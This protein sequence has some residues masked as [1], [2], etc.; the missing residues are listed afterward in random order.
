M[1]KAMLTALLCGSIV[2][3]I[4]GCDNSKQ[5]TKEELRNVNNVIIEYFSTNGVESY[6]N[7]IF[8]YVD[9][10]NG[11]VV[12]GLLN[13]DE[14]EQKNFKKEII[15]SDVIKFVKGERITDHGNKVATDLKP[16]V[17]TYAVLN[18]AESNDD[19]YIYLTIRQFQCEE[20]QTVKVE[21]DLCPDVVEGKIYEFTIK[22]RYPLE[23]TIVSI[24]NNSS[25]L[26]IKE[27]DKTGLEQIQDAIS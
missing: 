16:F 23:D 13:D 14:D 4:A 3:G 26:E 5:A 12:V 22:P 15:D 24:F 25:I 18:V 21:R 6:E 2:L 20:I 27:T 11:V 17:R 8:N 9:E 1:K 10:E 19:A 7:Y